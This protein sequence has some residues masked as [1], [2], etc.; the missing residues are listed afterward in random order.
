MIEEFSFSGGQRGRRRQTSAP[1]CQHAIVRVE[2][3]PDLIL[4]SAP[5]IS[6]IHGY[7][8]YAVGITDGLVDE[9]TGTRYNN[10]RAIGDSASSRYSWT[11]NGSNFGTVKG[12]IRIGFAS[13]PASQISS[14]ENNKIV[15]TPTFDNI[16][17]IPEHNPWNW[18]PSSTS[19][20][21]TTAASP[22][23][24]ASSSSP[25]TMLVSP[26]S[27]NF[28]YGQCAWWG[29]VRKRQMHA[30]DSSISNPPAD[31]Y[32]TGYNSID[33]TWVPRRGDQLKFDLSIPGGHHMAIVESVTAVKASKGVI[34]G[35]NVQISQFNALGGSHTNELSYDTQYFDA[36]T[37][38]ISFKSFGM[39][40]GYRR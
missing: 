8:D 13:V 30:E 9:S 14:W 26:M 6:A 17:S 3:L 35:Y 16:T 38:K 31:A 19:L 40:S 11:I 32:V 24:P 2:Q 20:V 18:V 15:F 25:M 29:H 5:A 23:Q 27:G 39:P 34:L 7:S 36:K 28:M 21:I 4:L 22:S 1:V 12:S 33:K 10:Y 37:R